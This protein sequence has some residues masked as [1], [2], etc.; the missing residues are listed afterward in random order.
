MA[1]MQQ[2]MN[3]I[4]DDAF[5]DDD[6]GDGMADF[7]RMAPFD[8]AVHVDDLRD[9]YVVHFNLPDK[10]LQDVNVRLENGEL[11]L[12]ASQA[13]KNQSQKSDAFASDTYEQRM[14]LPGPVKE[15]GMKVERENGMI[16]VTVPK[17]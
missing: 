8:S 17:A 7:T 13:Q 14:T 6:E 1:R 3:R 10:N 5:A 9:R 12:S 4:F 11:R 16:V 15:Q 2:Q